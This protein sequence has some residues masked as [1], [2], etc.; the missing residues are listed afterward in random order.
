MEKQ[1]NED[2]EQANTYTN[3]AVFGKKKKKKKEK[4]PVD[5]TL[6]TMNF[7]CSGVEEETETLNDASTQ[8][9]K[10]GKEQSFLWATDEK[11]CEETRNNT[12]RKPS[13]N[14]KHSKKSSTFLQ[15][16]LLQQE[17]INNEEEEQQEE[18]ETLL[19][20][21]R[22][23]K[24]LLL[25]FAALSTEDETTEDLE[26]STADAAEQNTDSSHKPQNVSNKEKQS[27]MSGRKPQ[28]GKKDKKPKRSAAE[29]EEID[30]II[31]QLQEP[32]TSSKSEKKKEEKDT[33]LVSEDIKTSENDSLQRQGNDKNNT[34]HMEDRS[35]SLNSSTVQGQELTANQKKKLKK[36]AAKEKAKESKE[37]TPDT[38]NAT[39]SVQVGNDKSSKSG[40][41]K[42]KES[43]ALRKM[44]EA[45]YAKK[46]EEE[47]IR[48]EQEEAERRAEEERRRE[49]EE[50]R[51]REEL[52]RQK[53][54][55]EKEKKRRLKQEGKLL[56]RAEKQKRERAM[57]FREQAIASGIV[58]AFHESKSS[59]QKSGSS[60]KKKHSKQKQMQKTEDSEEYTVESNFTLPTENEIEASPVVES[61]QGKCS[62]A[63]VEDDIDVS[64]DGEDWDSKAEKL[65]KSK[66]DSELDELGMTDST[67]SKTEDKHWKSQE[68]KLKEVKRVNIVEDKLETYS[69][70]NDSSSYD[71]SEEEQ[72]E[73][74]EKSLE[75]RREL[76]HRR[77][78]VRYEKAYSARSPDNLRAPVIC[79]LGHVDTGKTKILDKIRKTSVQEGEAGGITQQIGATYFPIER[80]KE[81][82]DKVGTDTVKYKIPALLIIDTPGHESFTNLRSRG[83]S[84]CDIAILVVDIMHGIEPQTMESIELLKQRKTPFIV[85]LNKVGRRSFFKIFTDAPIYYLFR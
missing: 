19:P 3:S 25:K 72:A 10:T 39:P 41:D 20:G 5:K 55:A 32:Q 38:L 34:D 48:R 40:K 21:Q 66:L 11:M 46:L 8:N 9:K 74:L 59:Q 83:S 85:A 57:Q 35:N 26:E 47:R 15:W 30:A 33:V 62:E 68:S 80:V 67:L 51:K 73:L 1:E 61:E 31:A 49:E 45:L 18:E 69:E 63:V 23:P 28:K 77:R 65:K 81:Q 27:S 43:A 82:V 44:K 24:S 22:Q 16:E 75:K 6:D 56:S 53:K 17:H 37:E 29:E 64:W 50:E 52:R 70:E 4:A 84:L 60:G 76:T 79:I 54:E 78:Q 36:K 13:T 71:D 12:A 58:P 2:W 42:K 7:N 14:E